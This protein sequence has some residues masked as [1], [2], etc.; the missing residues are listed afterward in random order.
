MRGSFRRSAL[1]YGATLTVAFVL[2]A[3]VP[4]SAHQRQWLQIGD[5]EYL[6]VVGFI[7]EPVYTGDKSGVELI[8]MTP[9]PANPVDSRAAAA[10]PVT[11]LEQSLKVEVKAGPHAQV[12]ELKP[13][14][15]T[16]G[17][18]Q[19]IFYPTVPTTYAFRFFGA[20][21]GIPIDLTFTCNP[22]GHVSLDDRT[23]VQVS[24]NV[25]RKAM[26]GSFGCPAAREEAEFP[27]A[28]RH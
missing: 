16:A 7:N 12:F 20:L 1:V 27:P 13:A 4:T 23:T 25:T 3:W 26:I 18:Y 15:G 6:L 22:L 21:Q 17:R 14:Y 10:K 11:A 2:L 19:A 8:V 24:A 9:D 5:A 28:A